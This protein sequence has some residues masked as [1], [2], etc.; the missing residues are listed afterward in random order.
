MWWDDEGGAFTAVDLKKEKDNSLDS[1]DT[2]QW[3]HASSTGSSDPTSSDPLTSDP[4]YVGPSERS[5]LSYSPTFKADD[6]DNDIWP[7]TSSVG[8]NDEKIPNESGYPE[9][10]EVRERERERERKRA[11][12]WIFSCYMLQCNLS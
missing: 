6:N 8:P 10:K 3:T 11:L 1:Q 9:G 4:M 12:H 2:S 5:L 7:D